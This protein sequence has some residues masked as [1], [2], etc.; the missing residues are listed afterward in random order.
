MKRVQVVVAVALMLPLSWLLIWL[1]SWWLSTV[2]G[3]RRFGP[4]PV[5]FSPGHLNHW[6]FEFCT[7]LALGAVVALALRSRSTIALAALCGAIVGLVHFAE[8]SIGV[9]SWAHWST[10]VWAYGVFVVPVVGAA[11]GA[12]LVLV[13]RQRSA[14][15][16]A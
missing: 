5:W 16:A 2:V 8:S 9:A 7:S 15:S 1:R 14:T 4:S 13:L 11:V 6:A 3:E 12:F 10:Y